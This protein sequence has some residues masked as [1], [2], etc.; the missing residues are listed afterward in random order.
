M[1]KE[2]QIEF[3]VHIKHLVH[4]QKTTKLLIISPKKNHFYI[5]HMVKSP[6]FGYHNFQPYEIIL[7]SIENLELSIM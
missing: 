7:F 2:G 1:K 3:P 5:L 6:I 4:V